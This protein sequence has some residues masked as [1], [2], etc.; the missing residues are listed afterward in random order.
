MIKTQKVLEE[1]I[2]NEQY[3]DA[4]KETSD[5]YTEMGDQ[6][7][8]QI[9]NT[10]EKYKDKIKSLEDTTHMVRVLIAGE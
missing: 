2:E 5:M 7:R 10:Q 6:I 1:V 3:V 9:K 8:E 4:V